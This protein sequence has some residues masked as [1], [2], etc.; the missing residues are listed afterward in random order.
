MNL[1]NY[2]TE[3]GVIVP[4]TSQI[5]SE[6][7]SYMRSQFG[8]DLNLEPE[9]PQG[10]L[11]TA[12]TLAIDGMARNNAKLANQINPLLS[13]GAHL[14]ALSSLFGTFRIGATR[15]IIADV[16]LTG[17]TGTVI[18]KGSQARSEDGDLFE[19]VNAIVLDEKGKG[20]VDFRAVEYGSIECGVG[21]LDS[22]ASSVLGWETVHNDKQAI[23]GQL[24]ESDL[25][26]RTRRLRTLARNNISTN[27]AIISSLYELEGV[28]SLSYLEN[29]TNAEQIIRGKTLKPHSVYVCIHGGIDEEIAKALK[30]NKTL[31]GGYNG[32]HSVTVVDEFSGQDYEVLFDRAKVV[33]LFCRVTVAKGFTSSKQLI[34]KAVQRFSRGENQADTGLIVG[35]E[36]SSFEIASAINFEDPRIYVR[37]VEL[38]KD[39]QTWSN[40]IEIAIDEIAQINESAVQVIEV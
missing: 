36:A 1:F 32:S 10:V 19:T 4:D 23:L 15:S 31:G 12:L 9:T 22:I 18:P 11:V 7:E 24:E 26:L 38:S 8:Q 20:A 14:D 39:G 25:S 13:T 16:K 33:D 28:H 27:E 5:R 37:N 6:I 17:R 2:I 35:R 21:E 3:T 30:D 40:V 29:Y 34:P